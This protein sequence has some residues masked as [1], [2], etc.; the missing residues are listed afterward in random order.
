MACTHAVV[1]PRR[2]E[3]FE[4]HRRTPPVPD[5]VESSVDLDALVVVQVPTE[6]AE[7]GPLGHSSAPGVRPR[8]R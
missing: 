3:L 5:L 2:R 4:W 1:S 6:H 7:V 8:V